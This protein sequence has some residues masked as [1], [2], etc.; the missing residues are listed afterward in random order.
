MWISWSEF[1]ISISE[2]GEAREIFKRANKALET[3]SQEERLMLLESWRDFEKNHGDKASLESV[4]KMM[5]RRVKKRKQIISEDG[6]DDGWQE[7][8]EYV[9]PQDESMFLC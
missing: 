7:Y 2:I 3:S 6:T 4:L 1:E 9:F 5:P 8:Y